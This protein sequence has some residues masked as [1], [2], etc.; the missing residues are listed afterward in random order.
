MGIQYMTPGTG[1]PLVIETPMGMIVIQWD[2]ARRRKRLM[3]SLPKGV[4]VHRGEERAMK[5]LQFLARR[6]DGVLVPDYSLLA[7]EVDESGAISGVKRPQTLAIRAVAQ[8]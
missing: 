5:D 6:A 7:P 1:L 2:A 4:H 8:G 3:V